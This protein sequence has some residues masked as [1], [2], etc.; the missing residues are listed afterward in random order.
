MHVIL[1]LIG[2]IIT[3]ETNKYFYEI[4]LNNIEVIS[5]DV[6]KNLLLSYD[7]DEDDIEYITI[8]CDCKNIKNDSIAGTNTEQKKIYIYTC[9]DKIKKQL[10]DIFITYGHKII[11]QNTLV[12]N[13]NM[14]KDEINENNYNNDN[15]YN[16]TNDNNYNETNDNNYNETNDN[17]SN[18]DDDN[19]SNDELDLDFTKINNEAKLLFDNKDFVFLLKTYLNKPELFKTFYKYISSGNI[20]INSKENSKE[21][22]CEDLNINVQLILNL[23]LGFSQNEIENALKYTGNHLNLSIRYLLFKKVE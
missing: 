9:K 12:Q 13:Q 14:Y 21:I 5:Y 22:S 10:E 19:E 4:R 7:I 23:N 3:E 15:N 8:T 1:K 18:D 11:L 17:E 20:L 2:H 6:M 16:E